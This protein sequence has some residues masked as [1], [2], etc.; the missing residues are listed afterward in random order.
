MKLYTRRGDG[1]VTGL[2]GG[3]RRPKADPRVEA[4]GAVDELNAALGVARLHVAAQDAGSRLE[5]VQ[6]DLFA[7]GAH[8]STPRQD[9]GADGGRA[10]ALPP[11][12]FDRVAEMEAWLDEAEDATPPLR[13]F[14]L[15]GGTPGAVHLHVAR[16]VCRRA[17]RRVVALSAK[18][19]VDPLVVRYLN[20]LSDYL[21]AA[22]RV[23]NAHCGTQDVEWRG[24]R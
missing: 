15:P 5:R 11:L 20:R 3:D 8:L 21:F 14:V 24:L 2:F 13:N 6:S 12:P 22:A 18:A 16:T 9:A 10:P 19:A 7:L 1:G 17:E 23:E 4:Y